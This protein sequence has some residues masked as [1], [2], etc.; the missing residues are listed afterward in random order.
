LPSIET[1]N[2]TARSDQLATGDLNAPLRPTRIFLQP[3]WLMRDLA[4][5]RAELRSPLTFVAGTRLWRRVRQEGYTML[6]CRRARTLY[7]LAA[8]AERQ[9]IPGALVDCGA[10]NGG[11]TAILAAGA[12]TRTAWAFD[13]FEGLP[14]PTVQDDDDAASW[15]GSCLGREEHVRE[16]FRRY[17]D[18]RQLRIV[19]GWFQDTLPAHAPEI[20][21][22]AVL[23]ADGDWFESIKLT[24][25]VL[26]AQVTVGGWVVVDDYATWS[27]ARKAVETFRA[28]RGIRSPLVHTESSAHWRK[29]RP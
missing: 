17:A 3:S 24:L 14:A 26:Y 12:P 19:K 8:E 21:P 16:A 25:E 13:S 23:H 5:M 28:E 2:V 27:G 18:P 9:G 22:I 7:R 11:S 4:P 1:M 15:K 29:A 20:G 10:W 6:G